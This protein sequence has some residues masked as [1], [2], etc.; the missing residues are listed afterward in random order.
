[1]CGLDARRRQH[2]YGTPAVLLVLVPSKTLT[3][4]SDQVLAALDII[5]LVASSFVDGCG[6]SYVAATWVTHVSA[7]PPL[8]GQ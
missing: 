4:V 1:V 5:G 3:A 6:E 2:S 8:L 7:L